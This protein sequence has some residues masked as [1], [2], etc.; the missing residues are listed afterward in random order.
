M[1]VKDL[2]QS[3]INVLIDGF[4][5]LMDDVRS[6]EIPNYGAKS[7]TMFEHCQIKQLD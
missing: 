2:Y 6:D 1:V 3:G 4:K 7:N 5:A